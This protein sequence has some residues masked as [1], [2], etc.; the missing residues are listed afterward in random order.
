ML[1]N[2]VLSFTP[3]SFSLIDSLCRRMFQQEMLGKLAVRYNCDDLLYE[4]KEM[5]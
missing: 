5:P 3:F 2:F 4:R 1:R